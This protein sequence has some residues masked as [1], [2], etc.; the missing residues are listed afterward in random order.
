MKSKKHN[1]IVSFVA[2][3]IIIVA[4]VISIQA[5]QK[6]NGLSQKVVPPSTVYTKQNGEYDKKTNVPRA[7]WNINAGPY[8][9]SPVE[10]ARQYLSENAQ[11]FQ[12]KANLSDLTKVE[13]HQN[14]GVSHVSLYQSVNNVPVFRSDVVVSINAE[15]VVTFLTNNYKSNIEIASTPNLTNQNAIEIAKQHLNVSGKYISEPTS[16]L[17][18]YAEQEIAKLSYRVEIINE[19][20]LGDWQVFVDALNGEILSSD[21]IAMYDKP[22]SHS[23]K[24]VDG[25]GNVYFPDP[26]TS[27]RT[28]YGAI[29]FTDNSGAD[30]PQLT[31][32]EKLVV[33]H[34][35]T[36]SG[37]VYKLQGP[38]CQILDFESPTD[39]FAAPSSPDSFQFTRSNN[40][41][42]EV[43]CY[44]WIDSSQRWM[45]SLGFDS[46]QNL[47]IGVDPNGLSG[48]DNSHYVPG[49]N[50]LAFGHGGVDDDQDIDVIWHEY[51]HAIQNG[52]RPG[53]G[54]G[55]EGG[56]GEGFGD[57]WAGSLSRA[58]NDTFSRNFVFTWDAGW[59]GT[60]GDA[61]LWPGRPLNDARSYPSNGTSGLEVHDAGQIWSAPL[62]EIWEDIG[63]EVM[64]KLV[65][66]SHYYMGTTGTMRQNAQAII[67]ADRDLYGG[68][69]I[70][71]LVNRFGNRNF[72]NPSDYLLQITHTP[73]TDTENL[74]GPYEVKAHVIPGVTAVD[75]NSIK[76]YWGRTTSFTDSV[77][78]HSTGLTNEY[79]GLI[80]GNGQSARY[81]YYITSSDT[82]GTRVS[83]PPNAPATY[84]S[85]SAG[86]V[87]IKPVITHNPLRD[88]GTSHWP[89][90]VVANVTDNLGVDSVWVDYYKNSPSSSNSFVLVHQTGSAYSG[91]F[92][93]DTSNVSIGDSIFY[94]IVAK[95]NSLGG[96]IASSPESGFY[97]FHVI[98]TLGRILIVN[99]DSVIGTPKMM[100]KGLF[101]S[102]AKSNRSPNMMYTTLTEAGYDVTLV[103]IADLDISTL[104]D[105][106][107][108]ISASGVNADPLR[109]PDYRNA[110]VQRVQDG[111]KVWV[112]GGEVG[113]DYRYTTSELDI[114]FRQ[115]ILRDSTW[116][117]DN[118]AGNLTFAISD[119]PIFNNP[120]TLTAPITFTSRTS[121]ADRDAMTMLEV[122]G[123]VAVG[124]WSAQTTST[125]IMTWSPDEDPSHC[126]TL[127]TTFAVGSITDSTVAK[128]LIE[129]CVSFVI[130]GGAVGVREHS[131]NEIP[132]VFSLH[133]NY[134]NPFNPVTNISFG[135]PV[136]SHV[137]LRIFNAIGQEVATI[138]NATFSAGYKEV[139]WNANTVSS[140]VYFY[141]LDAVPT[142]NTKPFTE[143][144]KMILLK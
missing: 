19:E 124:S 100:E 52:T 101:Q 115:N 117:A 54:G 107:L 121:W 31:A 68:A 38:Y 62:M 94:K 120:N 32:E 111:G 95:D 29:G 41:F 63:K 51:G 4:S 99:N 76:I 137:T 140:G 53:W 81:R 142:N 83:S 89:P 24:K 16:V 22:S 3:A 23:Q 71:V 78:M 18:V 79:S 141:R 136:E 110:I 60:G 25:S 10:I 125:S 14:F 55:E 48:A 39:V 97:S 72:I 13:L 12:M 1:Y 143:I 64:D 82:A 88:Q 11:L 27:S 108:V 34:D 128:G 61:G 134:P 33:L 43:M 130:N 119:H 20:P 59:N 114:N 15:N 58:F 46:I 65:L 85:F 127:F 123:L 112:E 67:Q 74:N 96:N 75:T 131:V 86:F 40:G 132:T 36:L 138:A 30:S 21:D 28:L 126:Q 104:G 37:N 56:M 106:E 42:E 44:F 129:N 139:S 47:S 98:A 73:I 133:Q 7:L 109:Y 26:L 135:L 93:L 90:K 5:K 113:Y 80:P 70:Q 50:R 105:Y 45:Q 91:Y 66:K 77:V 87:T 49:S 103:A 92:N 118:S 102:T 84:Y 116:H 6:H 8:S 17:M 2:A 35:I 9:G 144:R 57:Y 69:H 122:P